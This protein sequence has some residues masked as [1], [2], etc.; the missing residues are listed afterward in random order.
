MKGMV[1]SEGVLQHFLSIFKNRKLADVFLDLFF[2]MFQVVIGNIKIIAAHR[3]INR[4]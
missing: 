3:K 1:D 4:L 2:L